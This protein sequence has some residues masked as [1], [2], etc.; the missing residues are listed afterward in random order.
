MVVGLVYVDFGHATYENE[1]INTSATW[2]TAG[3]PYILT[4]NVIIESGA[5]LTIQPGVTVDFG[6]Y[7]IQVNGVLVAQGSSNN[8]IV[9][10][11]DGNSS[12]SVV[13][14]SSSYGSII[15]YVNFYAVCVNVQLGSPTISFNYFASDPTQTPTITVNSGSPAI[16]NNI[17]NMVSKDG[18]DVEGGSATISGNVIDGSDLNEGIY[19]IYVASSG[20]AQISEN[21]ITGCYSGIWAVGQSDIQRNNI[22]NNVNDGV[23]SQNPDSTIESNAIADNLCGVS[24]EG[25]IENNT[26]TSNSVGLWSPSG[27]IQYNNIYNNYNSSGGYTQNIHLT[28]SANL[29]AINN[30]WGST[31]TQAINQTIWDYKDDPTY[32]GL[33]FFV[34]F[35]NASNPFAP[36]I[37]A[38]IPVPTPPPTPAPTSTPFNTPSP[39]PYV[40][41]SQ[42]PTPTPTPSLPHLSTPKSIIGNLKSSDIDNILVIAVALIIAAVTIVVLN[43]RFGTRKAPKPS[44]RRKR[45]RRAAKGNLDKPAAQSSQ[46]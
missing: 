34:P 13:F 14:D 21:D 9:F 7:Q 43:L 25:F 18:I 46:G 16:N 6:N 38:S 3:S 8:V 17:I 26:I 1:A 30:W 28:N 10:S 27:T 31:D 39:T 22:M 37:P 12:T 33:V 32:L 23:C 11:G 29:V 45:K 36:S 15:S 20:Y 4:G 2:T 44:K 41:Y 40:N 42:T 24:G 5:T 35:L 19:G